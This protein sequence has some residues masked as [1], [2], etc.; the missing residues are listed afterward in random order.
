HVRDADLGGGIVGGLDPRQCVAVCVDGRVHR[1]RHLITRASVLY[2][3]VLELDAERL[4]LVVGERPRGVREDGDEQDGG[5]RTLHVVVLAVVTNSTRVADSPAPLQGSFS[6]RPARTG[7]RGLTSTSSVGTTGPSPW[8]PP[9][10]SSCQTT[11]T[12]RTTR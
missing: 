6:M 3:S 9:L 2:H 8:L 10:R 7:N 5:G 12:I 4:D 11:R 1:E